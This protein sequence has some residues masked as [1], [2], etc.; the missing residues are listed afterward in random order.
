MTEVFLVA[1][2]GAI[3]AVLRYTTGLITLRIVGNSRVMTGTVVAN[4]VGCLLAGMLLGWSTAADYSGG[5][6]VLFLTVGILGSYTTFSTFSLELSRLIKES[7]SKLLSYLFLQL[8]VAISLCAAGYA[9]T[10]WLMGGL[11]V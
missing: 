6:I 4:S 9:V 10:L 8:V 3:G 1:L 7:W 2:G 5:G 11:H